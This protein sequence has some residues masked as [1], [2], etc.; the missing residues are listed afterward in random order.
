MKKNLYS[1]IGRLNIFKIYSKKCTGSMT[2]QNYSGPFCR[3]ERDV[4]QTPMDL[5]QALS[6]Q[7]NLKE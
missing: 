4:L 5:Q 1:W 6:S 7:N 3:N 2:Y